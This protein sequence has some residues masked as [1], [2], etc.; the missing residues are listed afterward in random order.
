M[1]LGNDALVT[2]RIYPGLGHT[3]NQDEVDFVREMMR[4]VVG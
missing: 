2:K 1:P 3:V 4:S